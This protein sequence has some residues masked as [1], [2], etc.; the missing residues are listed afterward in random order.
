VGAKLKPEENDPGWKDAAGLNLNSLA[1]TLSFEME[2][3][4]A[5][6]LCIADAGLLNANLLSFHELLT[7]D[8][9]WE[10]CAELCVGLRTSPSSKLGFVFSEMLVFA[11]SLSERGFCWA[12]NEK[13]TGF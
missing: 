6:L 13:E 3:R 9:A 12:G 10:C 11:P 8:G 7:W 5:C 4:E 1:S 2:E